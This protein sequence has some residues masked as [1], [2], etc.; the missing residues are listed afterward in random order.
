MS[1]DVWPSSLSGLDQSGPAP[2]GHAIVDLIHY[3]GTWV[4]CRTICQSPDA[5][6][7]SPVERLVPRWAKTLASVPRCFWLDVAMGRL[8][9][10]E[11]ARGKSREELIQAGS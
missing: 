5:V 6:D 3:H 10:C 7:L 11:A 2:E 4:G 8:N 1:G 9:A